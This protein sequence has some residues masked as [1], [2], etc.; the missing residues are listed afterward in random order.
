MSFT[1]EILVNL[2]KLGSVPKYLRQGLVENIDP[3]KKCV[4]HCLT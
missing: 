4:S 1:Q 2:H 3:V